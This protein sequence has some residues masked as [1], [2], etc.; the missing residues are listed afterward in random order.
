MAT[1]Q[2]VPAWS[3]LEVKLE[4]SV[5]PHQTLLCKFVRTKKTSEDRSEWKRS[6]AANAAFAKLLIK[7]HQLASHKGGKQGEGT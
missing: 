1:E 6:S 5:F 3:C 4:G 2:N 7:E